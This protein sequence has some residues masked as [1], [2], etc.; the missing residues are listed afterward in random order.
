MLALRTLFLSSFMGYC[1]FASPH[2]KRIHQPSG[3]FFP[4]MVHHINLNHYEELSPDSNTTD[5]SQL[6]KR[7]NVDFCWRDLN[8]ANFCLALVGT[9]GTLAGLVLTATSMAKGGSDAHDC[10]SHVSAYD[11]VNI[12]FHATGRHCDTTA[13]W[14]TIQG[15]IKKFINGLDDTD[16]GVSCLKLTHGGTWAGYVTFAPKGTDPSHYHCGA[17]DEWNGCGS[18]GEK[19]A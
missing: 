5:I 17:A 16:C 13:Q 7:R 2:N 3:K 18:G 11:S 10:S 9:G 8:N 19:D 14:N 4:D 15:A 12:E 1:A 6:E